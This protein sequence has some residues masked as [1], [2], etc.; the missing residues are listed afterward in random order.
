M[1]SNISV[2]CIIVVIYI[3]VSNIIYI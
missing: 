2:I 3:I 1:I